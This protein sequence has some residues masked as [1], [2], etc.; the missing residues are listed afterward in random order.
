MTQDPWQSPNDQQPGGSAIPPPP[1]PAYPAYP[2]YSYAGGAYG[3]GAPA[4]VKP[5]MPRS[6]RIAVN[7]MFAGLAVGL[8]NMVIG[9]TQLSKVNDHLRS[10]GYSDTTISSDKGVFVAGAVVGGLIGTG[11]WLWMALATRAGQNYARIVSTVFFGVGVL[12]GISNLVSDWV[13]V[14]DKV[15]SVVTLA[16]GLLAIIFVWRGESGPYFAPRPGPGYGY[17]AYGIPQPPYGQPGQPPYGQPPYPQPGPPPYGQS[18][19]PPY[20]QG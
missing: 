2:G 1:S 14:I 9:L 17:H 12:G 6:V 4:A 8:I 18:G 20:G 16:V 15:S 19:Q 10:L 13:P 7:L 3:Y 11:L 5:P